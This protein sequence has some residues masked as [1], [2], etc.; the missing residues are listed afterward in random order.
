MEGDE[1]LNLNQIPFIGWLLDFVLKVSLALPF[2]L[3]WSVMG[4]GKKFFWFLPPVYLHPGFW[5]TVGVFVVV[6]IAYSIFIPKIVSVHNSQ[7]VGAS[8]K[9]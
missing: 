4:I 8:R 5:E 7:E 9:Q 1:M 2:W 6:P 3:I